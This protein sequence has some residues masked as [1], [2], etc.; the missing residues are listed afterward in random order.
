M[1]WDDVKS[2]WRRQNEPRLSEADLASLRQSLEAKQR[3]LARTLFWRDIREA[4]AGLFV[5]GVFALR[6]WR[7]GRSYWPLAVSVALV[8][9]VTGFFIAERIRSRRQRL[10]AGASLLAKVEAGLAE[11]RRQRRLLLNVS[12]WYIA[13][14]FVA[15][16]IGFLTSLANTPAHRHR[17]PV[18]LVCYLL[19]GIPFMTWG[20]RALN[21][22][23]VRRKIEPRLAELESLRADLLSAGGK[24]P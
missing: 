13:P 21:H 7:G 14:L 18:F 8:L 11:L 19:I 6:G 5:A 16:A 2:A 17:H 12:L 3:K 15:W 22:R 1:N 4:A 20:V 24:I 9:G 23:A 10:G